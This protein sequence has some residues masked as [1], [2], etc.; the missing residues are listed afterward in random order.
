M[1]Q[2]GSLDLLGVLFTRHSRRAYALCYR[3]VADSDIAEDLVQ[4]SFL[5]VIR[6]RDSFRGE[7][8]FTTWLHSIVRNVC[9][10]YL[11]KQSR[12]HLAASE[13]AADATTNET[14]TPLD[15]SDMSITKL[16][17]DSLTSEQQQLLVMSRIDGV[18][19]KEIASHLGSTEGAARVR[20]HRTML[21]LKSA[22]ER[23][24]EAQ[25]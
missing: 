1:I 9:L 18:G 8:R 3:M 19:Y 14:S 23:L 10:D 7:A 24:K 5:R 13:L 16:A 22:I 11:G 6:Y 15:D 25:S 4:E 2:E 17:F 12:E 21:A 20:V